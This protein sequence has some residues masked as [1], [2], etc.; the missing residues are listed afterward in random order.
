MKLR[1]IG[2]VPLILGSGIALAGKK[3]NRYRPKLKRSS[4][5]P[6]FDRHT[7]GSFWPIGIPGKSPYQSHDAGKL[8]VPAST[9][10]LFSSCRTLVL[11]PDYRFKTPVLKRD[12]LEEQGT[13]KGD[14]ILV[15]SGDPTLGGRTTSTGEIAGIS[16]ADHTY[17]S[18]AILTNPDPLAGLEGV[19]DAG[20]GRI[21][22]TIRRGRHH[23]RHPAL[24]ESGESTGSGPHRVIRSWSMIT[25]SISSFE[26]PT[27][28]TRPKSHRDAVSARIHVDASVVTVSSERKDSIS[29]H[30]DHSGEIIVRGE[31]ECRKKRKLSSR[32]F[33]SLKSMI[34]HLMRG[35]SL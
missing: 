17:E 14:L 26:P 20:G 34:R 2:L 27:L 12:S 18:Q 31:I 29:V 16:D 25:S 35:D 21:G 7:G 9:T 1:L 4:I 8:F 13:L 5:A 6:N 3:S 23:C 30:H 33:E 19:G 28:A 15:A 22:D 11:G 24:F 32:K 10:K